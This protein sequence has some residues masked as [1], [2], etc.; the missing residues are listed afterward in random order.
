MCVC[1]HELCV[2]VCV[3]VC[4]RVC[5]SESAESLQKLHWLYTSTSTYECT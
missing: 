4:V 3:C 5:V 1:D 2:C